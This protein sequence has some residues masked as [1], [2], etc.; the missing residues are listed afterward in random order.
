MTDVYHLSEE[1]IA[2]VRRQLTRLFV[3]LGMIL[4]PLVYFLPL[5][6]PDPA[7]SLFTHLFPFLLVGGFVV[8]ASYRAVK[9]QVAVMR[10]FQIW[11]GPDSIIRKQPNLPDL[12]I[13]RHEVTLIQ[14]GAG[15][16]LVIKTAD[17]LRFLPIPHT[18]E[19]Y[20][21]VRAYLGEWGD[22]QEVQ[23]TPQRQRLYQM[24]PFAALLLG[25]GS[26]VVLVASENPVLVVPAGLII[27]AAIVLSNV[28]NARSAHFERRPIWKVLLFE[29]PLLAI[30]ILKMLYDL[31][32][33]G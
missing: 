4:I 31:G 27:I 5:P 3:F 11:L 26:F 10:E 28:I 6:K 13:Q 19:E 22:I 18:L 29:V 2:L 12:E 21:E 32:L 20:K 17:S 14:E 15:S 7:S 8:F 24:M 30:A 9:Q 16:G 1:G 23:V 25:G 33:L